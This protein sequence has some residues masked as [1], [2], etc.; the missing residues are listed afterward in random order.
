MWRK[1]KGKKE[2]HW[3]YTSGGRTSQT[4]KEVA[5]M[6]EKVNKQR[7]FY[8]DPSERE[9][10]KSEQIEKQLDQANTETNMH[11]PKRIWYWEIAKGFG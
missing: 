10:N 1:D 3:V 8:S 4:D 9:Q 2:L 5:L 6:Q 7:K 11:R